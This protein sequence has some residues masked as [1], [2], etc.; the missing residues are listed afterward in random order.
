ME[1][2]R[3]RAQE[4]MHSR[5]MTA[6][7]V[8]MD[9]SVQSFLS[10]MKTGLESFDASLHM[11]PTYLNAEG[12]L[13]FET[14]VLVLD[15]GGTNFRVAQVKFSD[16]GKTVIEKFQKFPMPGSQGLMH[17]DEFFETIVDY[18]QDVLDSWSSATSPHIGFC[19][20]Y[21]TEITPDK[22]GRLLHFSK[23]I[24]AH[25]VEGELIG[26]NLR[27]SLKKRG[28]PEPAGMVLLNDTVATLLAGKAASTERPYSAFVGFILGTGTNSAYLEKNENIT[29]LPALP[30]TGSQIINI[31]SGGFDKFRGGSI[32]QNFDQTTIKPG[33]Y[34]FEKMISGAYLGPLSS[35]VLEEAVE[36]DLFSG[37]AASEIKKLLPLDTVTVDRFLHNPYDGENKLAIACATQSD[38]SMCFTLVD[39]ILERAAKLAAVNLSATILKGESGQDPSCPVAI[40][41]D[42]TTFFKSKDLMFR[43]RYYIKQYL[44]DQKG[45]YVE[46]IHNEDAPIIGAAVA[47]LLDI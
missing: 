24:N 36:A 39:T 42:G 29:K 40:C 14:P 46:F 26:T 20:S 22:D 8:D 9:Q 28:Y 47:A 13:P 3:K 41:A 10:E 27:Q 44:Q 18:M 45:R 35:R 7:E 34:R 23:E 32:D 37:A 38:R 17:K 11:I 43:T 12:E 25:E 5:S 30:S 1:S 2:S 31:E 19:F 4:F 16:R 15:A 21:P 33:S 6:A